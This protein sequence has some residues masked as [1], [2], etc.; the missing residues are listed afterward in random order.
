M[1]GLE[2]ELLILD[3]SISIVDKFLCRIPKSHSETS[4]PL[5]VEEKV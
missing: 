4:L 3:F 5:F 2:D 1:V